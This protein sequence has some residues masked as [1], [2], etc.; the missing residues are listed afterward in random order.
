MLVD[1]ML[2]MHVGRLHVVHA[3]C[4]CMLADCMLCMHVGRLGCMLCMHVGRLH[5]VPCIL[6]CIVG[7]LHVGT[8]MLSVLK[9]PI[10]TQITP[11]ME[12][13]D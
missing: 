9:M 5:V 7:R 10:L 2:C 11:H 3:Y 4:A 13:R 1:C 6:A 8:G 12:R